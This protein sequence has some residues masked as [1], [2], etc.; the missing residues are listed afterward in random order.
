MN[1]QFIHI[2]AVS[3]AGRDVFRTINN[4]RIKIG[5][6]SIDSVLGEASRENGYISH[7][8]KPLKPVVVYGDKKNGFETIRQKLKVWY[9]ETKDAREHKVR[10]DANALLAGVVSWPPI[11]DNEDKKEYDKKIASFE[12]D[13]IKWLKKEY[14][15]DLNLVLRHDDEPFHG[16]NA[17]KKHPHWHFLCAK[18]PGQKFNLHPGFLARS[19]YNISRKDRKNMSE[20]ELSKKYN[21]GTKAYKEAM[22]GYQDNFYQELGRFYG[23]ERFGPRWLR[24]SRSEQVELENYIN[25]ELE[26]VNKVKEET[27]IL[28]K[29]AKSKEN[30]A[31]LI[32]DDAEK[33]KKIIINEAWE[34]GKQ[35]KLAADNTKNNIIKSANIEK[36][37]IIKS[38]NIEKEKIIN[39]A[40]A[41]NEEADQNNKEADIY[42]KQVKTNFQKIN[43][44]II[45]LKEI[46]ISMANPQANKI[47]QWVNNYFLPPKSTINKPI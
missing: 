1:Y 11:N 7:I 25:N 4:K 31:Q 36:E 47:L 15:D 38:A 28:F 46:L 10:V 2:E 39:S 37:N 19:E 17:G 18:N 8:E 13:L 34:K 16:Q 21:E 40:K 35:I 32:K 6:I 20:N 12:K 29:Q 3:K 33:N 14:G 27:E 23:L 43:N 24:R 22:V 9:D 5:N 26:N 42:L 45:I 30:E 44:F 41:K